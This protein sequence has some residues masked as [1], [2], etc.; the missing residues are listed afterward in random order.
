MLAIEYFL[1]PMSLGETRLEWLLP[2]EFQRFVLR[3]KLIYLSLSIPIYLLFK[4]IIKNKLY[5]QEKQNLIFLLLIGTLI[6]F[7]AHQLMTINND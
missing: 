5:I 3:H 6:I 2:I 1:Y 4:N 7:I